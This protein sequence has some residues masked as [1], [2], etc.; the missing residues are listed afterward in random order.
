MKT[1]S[2]QFTD[3][4]NLDDA[5]YADHRVVCEFGSNRF[6]DSQVVTSS[7]LKQSNHGSNKFQ[8]APVNFWRADDAF[9]DK[10]Y[11]TMKWLVCDVG[12]TVSDTEDGTGY[13]CLDFEIDEE[14][15]RGWWSEAKSNSSGVFS[16]PEWVQSEFTA[17]TVN[18][19]T[20]HLTD[21]YDNMKEVTVQYKDDSGT[22]IDVWTNRV[23]GVSEYEITKDYEPAIQVAGLRVYVHATHRANDYARISELNA[24]YRVDVSDDIISMDIRDSREEYEEST[25]PIGIHR[26]NTL[27]FEL[28]NTQG[29]YNPDGDSPYAPYIGPQVRVMPYVGVDLNAGEGAPNYEYVQM[30]EFWTDDFSVDGDGMTA[31]ASCRDFSKFMQDEENTYGYAWSN[32]DMGKIAR[33]ILARTGLHSSRIVI[34]ANMRGFSNVYIKDESYWTFLNEVAFA[35][36][37]TFGFDHEGNFFLHSYDKLDTAPYN[38]SSH[39]L[40]WDRNI[41]D[42]S[43]RTKIYLNKIV[44]TSSPVEELVNKRQGIWSPP[45]DEILQWA[46]L[47]A[48]IS[49]SD[50][51]IPVIRAI[52]QD[53]GNLTDNNWHE[54]G[55]LFLPKY[56]ISEEELDGRNKYDYIIGGE[57]IKYDSRTDSAFTDCTRGYLDTEAQAWDAGQYIGEARY[58]EMEFDK[59]PARN[60]E[61]FVTA[62]DTLLSVPDIGKPQAV[63][64]LFEHDAFMGKLCVANLAEYMTW[65]QGTGQ[66][67]HDLKDDSYQVDISWAT[68]VAG[69]VLTEKV[70][71]EKTS[72]EAPLAEGEVRDLIRRY[73]LN[74]IEIDNKWIQ[75]KRHAKDIVDVLITEYGY[76]RDVIDLELIGIP[77][78][79]TG[80]RVTITNFPQLEIANKDYH[81]ID[82][83]HNYDGGIKTRA[84]VREVK[85]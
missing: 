71:S 42:G 84:T 24:Y 65:L 5:I 83:S 3:I 18:N 36:Q 54:S 66:S 45:D 37:G 39:S 48:S 77:H 49:A 53:N 1:V 82:L 41:V 20:L 30:G 27:N 74:K 23:L 15:E 85:Q 61:V 6:N 79:S 35:D 60:I 38:S 56:S 81:V 16:S 78:M 59:A 8:T 70:G 2:A 32:I 7:S 25:V 55:I 43:L 29:N 46:E 22:W 75:N 72:G 40:S 57:L 11:N 19:I 44:I 17:R 68:A 58:Y 14:L 80:D 64:V 13:R 62:I 73:G 52:N 33:D 47:G 67:Y 10:N 4:F 51:T 50:T 31:S 69:V 28:D 12:A 76:P 21:C 9:N 26:A 34:D 63:V